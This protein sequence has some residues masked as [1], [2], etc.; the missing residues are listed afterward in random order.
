MWSRRKVGSTHQWWFLGQHRVNNSGSQPT[1]CKAD[2]SYD[3][4]HSYEVPM[5]L[6]ESVRGGLTPPSPEYSCAQ[7]KVTPWWD[8]SGPS[9]PTKCG[10]SCGKLCIS[11][12]LRNFPRQIQGLLQNFPHTRPQ[13]R[14][15]FHL[16]HILCSTK[17]AGAP[18][19]FAEFQGHTSSVSTLVAKPF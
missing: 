3:S 10:T 8:T 9:A 1:R 18:T 4:H 11:N 2:D 7:G 16:L 15:R 12:W 19:G 13:G 14:G 5:V 17:W 6:F